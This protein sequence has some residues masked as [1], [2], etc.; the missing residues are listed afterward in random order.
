MYIV[1]ALGFSLKTEP[2]KSEEVLTKSSSSGQGLL[3][4]KRA[5]Q[6]NITLALKPEPKGEKGPV[7]ETPGL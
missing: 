4:G 5:I 7:K 6:R 2:W 1:E 3:W